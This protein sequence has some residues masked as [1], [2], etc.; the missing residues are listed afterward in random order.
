MIAVRT[1][2]GTIRA[3]LADDDA[4]CRLL[5][6]RQLESLGDV[7]VHAVADGEEAVTAFQEALSNGAKY[8]AVFL[9]VSMPI[10][11]GFIAADIIR[12]LDTEPCTPITMVTGTEPCRDVLTRN[13][14][15]GY[16]MK[17]VPKCLLKNI[18]DGRRMQLIGGK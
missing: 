3:L 7:V 13:G 6:Q 1:F 8:D 17:P 14:V 4:S 15:D 16:L 5:L 18:I 10:M 2:S 12:N 11:S 9:D